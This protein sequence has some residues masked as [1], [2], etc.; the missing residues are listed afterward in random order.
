MAINKLETKI[1]LPKL[2]S[3]LSVD[4]HLEAVSMAESLLVD[5]QLGERDVVRA[6]SQRFNI[7]ARLAQ[8]AVEQA[9]DALMPP[10]IFN[11]VYRRKSGP[12]RSIANA[13]NLAYYGRY[14]EL[15]NVDKFLCDPVLSRTL[16][17]VMFPEGVQYIVTD[18]EGEDGVANVVASLARELNDV[19]PGSTYDEAVDYVARLV[20]DA[21][22]VTPD[23]FTP[24]EEFSCH[25][26]R[27]LSPEW[28]TELSDDLF[29]EDRHRPFVR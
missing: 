8:Q 5:E 15:S 1:H 11:P 28:T 19:T 22:P 26:S 12:V 24:A 20:G 13:P 2:G 3:G 18:L 6:V 29:E 4:G 10:T 7:S 16:V 25:L 9:K 17:A 27:G 21:V 14:G 23:E